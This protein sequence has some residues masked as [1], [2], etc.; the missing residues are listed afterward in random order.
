MPLTMWNC[1]WSYKHK[2]FYVKIGFYF[3]EINCA[4]VFS[5][6]NFLLPTF[7]IGGKLDFQVVN[8]LLATVNFDSC[9]GLSSPVNLNLLIFQSKFS[10][11]RKLTL[12]YQ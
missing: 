7:S 3:P 5:G 9:L 12:R 4:S 10:G 11:T 1:V 2:N 8:L 6:S